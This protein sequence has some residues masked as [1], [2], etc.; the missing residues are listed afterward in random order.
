M[1][2][3]I[4]KTVVTISLAAFCACS[5]TAVKS[6]NSPTQFK[7]GD[8]I[9]VAKD[10]F[11][12]EDS[13]GKR[14]LPMGG[15]YMNEHHKKADSYH[16]WDSFS[17]E[18][19][20]HDFA[21][22]KRL[23]NN[24]VRITFWLNVVSSNPANYIV[25]TP[26]DY[27]KIDFIVKTA[28]KYG[29][30]LYAEPKIEGTFI[31]NTVY[32][33]LWNLAFD[34]LSKKYKDEEAIFCWELDA[35]AVSLIGYRGDREC[36]EKWLKK[37]YG[38]DKNVAKAWNVKNE[39]DWK[40]KTYDKYRRA[41]HHSSEFDKARNKKP[42][43]W[44]LDSLN[45][46]GSQI[47]YDWQLFREHQY[48]EK[49]RILNNTIR[50]ND[51]NHLVSIDLVLWF[52]PLVRNLG[53]AGWGGPY[54]YAAVDFQEISK[55][56]DFIGIHS[57][58]LYIPAFTTEWYENL[59]KDEKIFNRQLRY[60]ETMIRY[61][62]ANVEKPLPV[63]HSETGWHGGKGDYTGNS[64]KDQLIWSETLMEETKDC[65][66]GWMNWLIKDIP[67]HEGLSGFIGMVGP[68]LKVTNDIH[69]LNPV[70]NYVYDGPLPKKDAYK[71][72]AFGKKFPE[73]V[74]KYHNDP[75]VKYA[76][77]KKQIK[78]SKKLLL[79]AGNKKLDKIMQEIINSTN[80]P[81]DIILE[82]E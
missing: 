66:V 70:G 46:E 31:Q 34:T 18:R 17:E 53:P 30:R 16:W 51:T 77:A 7:K 11:T 43:H 48:T 40:N 65:A 25:G 19:L 62:H 74:K 22:A 37:K 47:L 23:G 72:K 32:F 57:Y 69:N 33:P 13:K 21:M 5:I 42:E 49:M 52:F 1:K 80:F 82:L 9:K 78:L 35:E 50:V 76:K 79:T 54:G 75:E 71:L 10:N 45:E 81:V 26:E 73:L 64:E 39:K 8:F 59:T 3:I 58:P 63:V 6:S 61:I 15:Y 28:R 41:L 56:V 20:D 68:G 55:F 36:W 12:F 60:L 67:S 24:T 4:Q 29:L 2:S 14:F 44:Y 27:D 38:S